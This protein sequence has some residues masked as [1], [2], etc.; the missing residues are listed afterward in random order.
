[1]MVD[2]SLREMLAEAVAE[3]QS[4]PD[5]LDIP[6]ED[7]SRLSHSTSASNSNSPGSTSAALSRTS[8]NEL[9]GITASRAASSDNAC[10]CVSGSAW[11]PR[12]WCTDGEISGA[13]LPP[14]QAAPQMR[15]LRR[16]DADE[17][18]PVALQ[19]LQNTSTVADRE[20][21]IGSWDQFKTNQ[22]LFGVASTYK[23]D[24]SQYTTVLDTEKL[25]AKLRRKAERLAREIEQGHTSRSAGDKD[26]VG[27]D[28]EDEEELWSAVPRCSKS[29]SDVHKGAA[30]TERV[31]GSSSPI[32]PPVSIWS[33]NNRV[34]PK[35]RGTFV[36]VDGVGL[37]DEQVARRLPGV[38]GVQ[39][40][41]GTQVVIEGL[42]KAPA[43]NGHSGVV[44][45]FDSGTG[46]YNIQLSV[47]AC[48]AGNQIAKI[49]PENLR[50]AI[51]PP[52]AIYQ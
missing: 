17:E 50:S 31:E 33:N 46:R 47:E 24:L 11:I 37:V 25:P 42:T 30:Q 19:E 45:S 6:Q 15:E 12:S 49:K 29:N 32:Q 28:G 1:M 22:T 27:S 18:V 39:F 4:W 36:L 52:K 44:L 8:S 2:F 13:G 7:S 16:W 3:A 43:F 23:D 14:C 40:T 5:K 20:D 38:L 35:V 51:S 10:S 48:S 9:C 26:G 21:V 41:P 34:V